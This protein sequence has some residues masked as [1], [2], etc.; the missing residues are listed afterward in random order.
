MPNNHGRDLPVSPC[1]DS[2]GMP[3]IEALT[4]CAFKMPT[5]FPESDGTF[6]WDA[7]TL[8][9]AEVRAGSQT[10]FGYTYASASAA[11]VIRRD[12][13]GVVVGL[14]PMSIPAAARALRGALRNNG[15]TGIGAMAISAVDVALW[16]LKA[17]LLGLPLV[18]LLGRVR[19]RVPVYG[20]GGFTSYTVPQLER[21]LRGW[22]ESGIPRVKMKIGREP[23]ADPERVA[24]AWEAV[25]GVNAAAELMVDANGAY[26]EKQAMRLGH[27]FSGFGVTWFE[28][29]VP[30]G[31]PR[32]LD[33]LRRVRDSV[34]MEVAGGEYA[35]GPGDFTRLISSVDVLQAD[36]TRCLGLSGFL[37]A[38]RIADA[39]GLPLSAHCAPTLHRHLGACVENFR[40]L[41][42]FH[43]H[44]RLERALFDGFVEPEAGA[45]AN[46]R[47]RPGLGIAFKHA[48][49]ALFR[50]L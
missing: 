5:D 37:E 34:P 1:S 50:V 14:D 48:D 35:Y 7:T 41:E 33:A 9:V 22:V 45:L 11:E 39:A 17:R 10:G 26:D 3:P 36:A 24:R 46:D 6:A 30:S 38:G 21:Q 32:F 27:V 29:P 13:A 20:S 16:D 25:S 4:A 44:V 43:D 15:C 18:D 2:S 47:D 49:A 31:D 23:E 19:D 42:W 28:E 40:H 12:L 8:I